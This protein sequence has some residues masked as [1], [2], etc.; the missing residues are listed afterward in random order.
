MLMF[1]TNHSCSSPPTP[2]IREG[3]HQELC[4]ESRLAELRLYDFQV[5]ACCSSQAILPSFERHSTLPGV[6]LE[7]KG[8]FLGMIS[9]QRL[10]EFLLR[11]QAIELFVPQPLSVLYSYA[12]VSSLILPETMP[13]LAAAQ[14][15]LRRPPSQHNEPIVVVCDADDEIPVM[16]H[17]KKDLSNSHQV[18]S[19]LEQ[20]YLNRPDLDSQD[21]DLDEHCHHGDCYD[22]CGNGDRIEG[23]RQPTYYL[24]D[25]HELNIAYWQIRGI[26]TQVRYERSQVQMVQTEK[27]ASLGRLVDGVA[28]EIL[29]PVGFIWGNLV[30]LSD[31]TH[32]VMGLLNAYEHH[33]SDRMP[34]PIAQLRTEIELDYLC[35]D[36]P[37]T[38]ASIRAGAERLK[39]LASSLQNFCHIDDVYPKPADLHD[40]LDSILLL[41]KSHLTG[42]I[43]IVRNYGHLPPVN[44]YAGQLTQVFMNIL[45]N[46]VDVLMNQAIRQDLADNFGGEL[47]ADVQ[48]YLKRK[49][50]IT[51]TTQVRSFPASFHPANPS[52]RWVS[53][54]IFDNG[55][56]L[57]TEKQ[58]QILAS[59]SVEKR[60][61]KETSLA[62]SYQIVT[63]KHGGKFYLRSPAPESDDSSHHSDSNPGTEFEILL[64]LI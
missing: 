34:S 10:L 44:C 11:P 30:H 39:N 33:F 6:V 47:G 16:N 22:R 51:I 28:H 5:D 9:R 37:Q 29:D 3:K 14:L 54:R 43:E 24:L 17:V 59:F 45:S 41:L 63:A 36:I 12:R 42:E 15:A 64:P 40:C 35:H 38:I 13:I 8:Q 7:E 18:R 55:P 31:Y 4:L 2:S 20:G 53:I 61:D 25:S 49:P 26:E 58:Q 50:Q 62:M 27:M 1:A 56:G 52:L 21:P 19:D 32:Q 57:S 23:A 60:A 46:A 48:Q